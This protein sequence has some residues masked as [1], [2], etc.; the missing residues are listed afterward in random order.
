[1][2]VD[3]LI[4]AIE[5]LEEKCLFDYIQLGTTVISVFISIAAIVFAIRVPQKIADRQDRISLFEKRYDCYTTIQKFL[6]VAKQ[7]KDEKTKKAIQVAFRMHLGNAEDIT[8]NINLTTFLVFLKQKESI[9]ISGEFLFNKYDAKLLQEI[10]NVSLNLVRLSSENDSEKLEEILSDREEV[11][12]LKNQYC[13]LC[14]NF[15]KD[16]F[17][18]LEEDLKIN[19]NK[20]R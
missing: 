4:I 16:Y 13:E 18:F 14:N 20:S 1:M 9:L 5:I 8:K 15:I 10:L 7:I 3:D 6:V 17:P 12:I 11:I 19:F 2:N